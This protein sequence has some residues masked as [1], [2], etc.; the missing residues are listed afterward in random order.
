MTVMRNQADSIDSIIGGK[1]AKGDIRKAGLSRLARILQDIDSRLDFKQGARGW[2]YTLENN[3]IINKG[4]FDRT[5]EAIN[6]CRKLGLLPINF[7]AEDVSRSWE[8][9][10][11]PTDMPIDRFFRLYIRAALEAPQYFVPDW[12]EGEGR[13]SP[14][15][16]VRHYWSPNMKHDI[17]R[18]RKAIDSLAEQAI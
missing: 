11:E 2:C 5:E 6:D 3:N 1:T 4:E 13:I 17:E 18:V 15:I 14:E 7:C 10:E 16:L 9:V 12:W 8:G